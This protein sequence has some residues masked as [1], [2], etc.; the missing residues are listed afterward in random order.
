MH[1]N[2]YSM[3]IISVLSA[4]TL[5][6]WTEN[7]N[8]DLC[9]EKVVYVVATAHLD[10]QWRWTIQKTINTYIPDTLKTNF[11]FFE[12]YPHY[13]FSFEGAFRYMLI[14]EYYPEEYEKLKE[15]IAKGRW[16]VCGSWVD[17][18]DTN[19]PS[20]ESLIRHALYGN[21]FFKREFGKTSC[22]IF[23][24][25]CFGFGFAL[26]S[27][28]VHCG[29]KGFSTQ[30]LT[31]GSA[32]EIPFDIGIWKGVD[33]SE[34]VAALKPGVYTAQL[35]RDISMDEDRAGRLEEK[36]KQGGIPVG[37]E[38]F[39]T[40]DIGGGP[41]EQSVAFIEQATQ[42]KEGKL[43]VKNA[44]ADQLFK[45]LE[46][47]DFEHL[48]K[49][50]G[51]LLLTTHATG[52][53]TAQAAMKRWNR[54]NELLAHAAE[55]AAVM[56]DWLQTAVYPDDAFRQAW[57]RFLWHQFHDDLTGTSIPEAYMFS[58]ND[59][60]ISLGQFSSILQHAVGGVARE[61]DT[62]VR[63]VPLIVFNPL[64]IEREDAVLATVKFPSPVPRFVKVYDD[65]G[66]ERPSQIICRTPDGIEL[67][68]IA[69]VPSSGFCVYEVRPSSKPCLLR[70]SLKVSSRTIENERYRLTVDENGDVAGIF[71]KEENSEVLQEPIRFQLLDNLSPTFPAWEILYETVAREP[72]GYVAAP[73]RINVVEE[74]P[75]RAVLEI[76]RDADDSTF[77]QRI[78]LYTGAAKDRIEFDNEIYWNTKET[79]LKVA[80]PLAVSN[81]MA[82]YDLGL[83]TIQRGR[84]NP[85]LYEVPAQQWADV[86]CNDTG[87]GISILN[88]CKYGWDKP[89]DNMLRL[90]LIHTPRAGSYADQSS[91]D[92]GHHRVKY[93]MYAHKGGWQDSDVSWQAARLN[94]PLIA[95][96]TTQHSG[97]LGK[98]FSFL[99]VSSEQVAVKALKKTEDTDEI[100][101]RFH[102][103]S[104]KPAKNISLHI[105]GEIIQAREVNG[106]EETI[107]KATVKSGVLVFDM[108][109]YKPRAFAV[110]LKRRDDGDKFPICKVVPLQ[111]DTRA[112]SPHNTAVEYDF[113]G[114]GHLLPGE[115]LPGELTVNDIVFELP[116]TG[117]KENNVL[118]CKGQTISIPEGDFSH[119]YFLANSID[120]DTTGSFHV[121]GKETKITIH[122]YHENIGQ[123]N[124]RLTGGTFTDDPTMIEPPYWKN[125]SI[126]WIGTHLHEKD[127]AFDPY[128]YCYLFM[129]AIPISK[130]PSTLTL[131]KDERIKL[132]ALT[133]ADNANAL[134]V[135]AQPL[136]DQLSNLSVLVKTPTRFFLESIEVPLSCGHP[137]AEIRYTLN[138]VSP[139][140]TS[141]LY[142]A[143][144]KISDNATISA[145][146]FLTNGEHGAVSRVKFE[147][148]IPLKPH[149]VDGLKPGLEYIYYEGPWDI[150]PDFQ[151]L[152]PSKSGRMDNVSLDSRLRDEDFGFKYTGY[153]R[154]PED[155]V[156]VFYTKSDDGSRF[157]VA[158]E[159][160]VNNDGL[161]GPDA[162]Y[163]TIA[164]KAGFHPIT[165]LYFQ[166]KGDFFLEVGCRTDKFGDVPLEPQNL[167]TK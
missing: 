89:R 16:R 23:L 48:E 139:S 166:H 133:A 32:V 33:G 1:K 4:L 10:T 154:I 105:A 59:E 9:N 147:K 31:W 145:R 146:A 130:S 124:N 106:V 150:L 38:Y 41:D 92:I 53:Y 29:L 97:H 108:E 80:F 21:G 17:A 79:L 161:H 30:K 88:D 156:Y 91:M 67:V 144:L 61:L 134:T 81:S 56:A 73:A 11:A 120:G 25:D 116:N 153:I 125:V 137:D 76:S 99:Q 39:G 163:G 101:V 60:L 115:L 50:E 37:Y 68:F 12:K 20:P 152:T 18:V 62:Q 100:I 54:K 6:G 71:D 24:P 15:Y 158:G 113:D 85:E 123:W 103:L 36:Q 126:A 55:S 112:F 148:L 167:F 127:G 157:Y 114:K 84:N 140:T 143:P 13:V 45:D 78:I 83:G 82:T 5:N 27:I 58:W 162:Q 160:V 98:K 8:P 155:A 111:F 149:D 151:S 43:R 86:T 2:L 28:A 47:E 95:F 128:S 104:G 63:G 44:A 90:T 34:I 107:G 51:E 132:F 57:I 3:I 75:A 121:N 94:Q 77:I 131:P 52:C 110:R 14:K 35:D 26:P 69:R 96:Q 70:S 40:G 142:R 49:Y 118:T 122:D 135:P 102:E 65:E 136:F 66:R 93:G 159:E 74:G 138:S 46:S 22:D 129:Y 42:N 164:L 141:E 87:Y 109:P 19:I 64:S 7:M 72:R 119:I 117:D 165:L